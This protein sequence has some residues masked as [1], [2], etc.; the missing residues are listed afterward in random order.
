MVDG[1]HQ[2]FNMLVVRKTPT[3][4]SRTMWA[5]SMVV[6]HE[7][8]GCAVSLVEPRWNRA[9]LYCYVFL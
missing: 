3:Q 6:H 7:C 5:Q 8:L 2:M 1:T 9:N 4:R